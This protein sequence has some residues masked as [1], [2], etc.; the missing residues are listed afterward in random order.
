M[1]SIVNYK[2]YKDEIIYSISIPIEY[3]PIKINEDTISI[4]QFSRIKNEIE[5]QGSTC[6]FLDSL[7]ISDD[8]IRV[9]RSYYD[10]PNSYDE[11]SEIFWTKDLGLIGVYN[12]G[13]WG[14]LQLVDYEL[15]TMNMKEKLYDYI[16]ERHKNKTIK[17]VANNS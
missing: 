14:V 15:D 1:N 16:I 5:Y 13:G 3:Y 4:F 6:E 17:K 12:S 8:S 2:T 11:E 7:N 9:Y 10:R